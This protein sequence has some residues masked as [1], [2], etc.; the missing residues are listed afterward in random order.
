MGRN[1]VIF[2][3]GTGARGG[4]FVDENRSNIYK[5]F[6]ATRCGPDS[7]INPTEQVAFYDPGIGTLPP[8]SGFLGSLGQRLYNLI[9]QALG[10]GITR[11]IIDCYA[12]IIQ[13]YRPNDRIFLF[14]FSRGAYTI[15]CLAAAI[16][17]CGIPTRLGENAPMK[18]DQATAR[19][20]A[21]E[22]VR[23]V[24]QHTS[25]WVRE[26]ATPDQI[27][28][29]DQR[30]AIAARFRKKYGSDQGGGANVYPHFVGVFDTVASLS[31]P[32][33]L[34]G[35]VAAGIVLMALASWIAWL[36]MP[37]LF[38]MRWDW[39]AMFGIST[40]G[41][42]GL[43]Y[44]FNLL[45]RVRVVHMPPEY[46]WWK[47]LHLTERRMTFYDQTLNANVS[48]A[49][50]AISIDEAR[51]SFQ[52]VPWGD[53]LVWKDTTP[54]WFEQLWFAGNHSDIGGSYPE[55]YARMS[56]ISLGWMVEAAKQAGL[57]VNDTILQLYPDAAGPQHDENKSSV[58]K[59]AAALDRWLGRNG[60]R[61]IGH[62]FPLHSSVLQR[63][64]AGP[65]LHYDV[66]GDY[67]PE[68]LREHDKC[69]RYY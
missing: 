39:W 15:R 27:G 49:R 38:G 19:K 63:F 37:L 24:Y 48:F 5:L 12:A 26:R 52:R 3:D 32:I 59:Y 11:N 10:I 58:F 47:T 31:N 41:T 69:K 53:P 40:A 67:R 60:L 68:N 9:S 54:Q 61:A 7:P 42:L 4:V 1:I 50:H 62:D 44:L 51:Y 29:L 43:S 20:L 35:L 64:E 21:A 13:L 28:L 56:D 33:A 2:S 25:S 36:V 55:N 65:V 66:V 16:C 22:A 23:K 8:G 46:P 14:G 45:T 6:R 34:A 30:D 18:Y 57:K 17:K